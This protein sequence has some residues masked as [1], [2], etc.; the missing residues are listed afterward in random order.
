MAAGSAGRSPAADLQ[1]AAEQASKEP[2][3]AAEGLGAARGSSRETLETAGTEPSQAELWAKWSERRENKKKQMRD[4]KKMD[5]KIGRL[6]QIRSLH[7]KTDSQGSQPR[8]RG[9]YDSNDGASMASSGRSRMSGSSVRSLDRGFFQLSTN[10]ASQERELEEPP[11]AEEPG[12]AEAQRS[13][14]WAAEREEVHQNRRCW[15]KQATEGS[16]EALKVSE[17]D[18]SRAD[19]AVLA[20]PRSAWAAQA[21]ADILHARV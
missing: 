11:A 21:S 3:T 16:D 14:A 8:F 10:V 12:P 18:G 15:G 4:R 13:G 6:E 2:Q 17:A 9:P 19:A 1:R 7:S 20:S 5:S